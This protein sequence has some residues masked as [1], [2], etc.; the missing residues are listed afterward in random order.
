MNGYMHGAAYSWD[1]SCPDVRFVRDG[2][3]IISKNL[4]TEGTFEYL[5]ENLK[6]YAPDANVLIVHGVDCSGVI[7]AGCAPVGGEPL[8][9]KFLGGSGAYFN[10]QLWLHER[11][12]NVG[13]PHSAES[14]DQEDKVDGSIG[15]RF[16]FWMLG[17]GHYGKTREECSAFRKASFKSVSVT[18]SINQKFFATAA[19]MPVAANDNG[20]GDVTSSEPSVELS[21]DLISAAKREG[22]T[23]KAYQVIAVPWVGGA[24]TTAI[25]D[26]SREDL[27][28]IRHLLK[29][30]SSP[31]IS[32]A[33][34]VL[35]ERGDQRDIDILKKWIVAPLPASLPGDE[36]NATR[37]AIRQFKQAKIAAPIALG[38]LARRTKSETAVKILKD[39]SKANSNVA[40]QDPVVNLATQ[41]SAIKGLSVAD[42]EK[43]KEYVRNVID[44]QNG[45][46]L[47]KPATRDTVE[48]ARAVPLS[49]EELQILIKQ[50][51]M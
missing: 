22:L 30:S 34:Q 33:L 32:Q 20:V 21:D 37:D 27:D 44:V 6:R 29:S 17:K 40:P 8:I 15:K 2:D 49:K 11:G 18:P 42:T 23:V 41:K 43:S 50:I 7:A 5:S 38:G 26:L 45:A 39:V 9:A 14:P 31:F 47:D 36:S 24:P 46:P 16:M 4:A 25:A 35:G 13:L 12:H 48:A 1:D 3:V 28:S 51:E 19:S 10:P